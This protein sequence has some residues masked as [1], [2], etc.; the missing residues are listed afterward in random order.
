[1]LRM[2][3]QVEQNLLSKKQLD[4]KQSLIKLFKKEPLRAVLIGPAGTEK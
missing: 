4:L 3:E 1:M 2:L